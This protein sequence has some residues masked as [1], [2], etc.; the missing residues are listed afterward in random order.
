MKSDYIY[1]GVIVVFI[2]MLIGS[3]YQIS[4]LHEQI[5]QQRIQSNIREIEILT[6]M[7]VLTDRV[8]DVK[9]DY[10]RIDGERA[11]LLGLWNRI[12]PSVQA[13]A[14]DKILEDQ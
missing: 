6:I 12:R 3:T 14:F 4:N 8:S 7:Q 9:A 1:L 10:L 13:R 11:R 2:A 5:T